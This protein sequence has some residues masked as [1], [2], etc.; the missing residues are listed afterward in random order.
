MKQRTRSQN[1]AASDLLLTGDVKRLLNVIINVRRTVMRL[2][3]L[4]DKS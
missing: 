1:T 2:P 4:L 3:G